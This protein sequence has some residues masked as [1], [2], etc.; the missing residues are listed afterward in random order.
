MYPQTVYLK[1]SANMPNDTDQW[2]LAL[3]IIGETKCD[4]ENCVNSEHR[5]YITLEKGLVNAEFIEEYYTFIQK[6]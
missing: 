2:P 6:D 1:N 4:D 5:Q 3:N